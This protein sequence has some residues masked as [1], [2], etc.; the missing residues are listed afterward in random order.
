MLRSLIARLSAAALLVL[1]ATPAMAVEMLPDSTF[2]DAF[3]LANGLE[4][5][6]RH[7]PG[8]AAT[9]VTV[10]YRAGSAYEPAGREGLASLMAELQFTAPAGDTPERTR[11]DLGTLRPTGWGIHTNEH[12]V[13]LTEMVPN[14]KFPG[15]LREVGI[16]MRGVTVTDA[17][18]KVATANVR[19]DL[20]EL[21]FTRTDAALFS[22]V[23][24]LALGLSDEQIVRRA[25]AAGL[26]GL[27]AKDVTAELHKR[28]VP[29]NACI[30]LAGDF[31]AYNMKKLLESELGAIPAGAVQPEAPAPV[32]TPGTRTT[33][34]D[35]V[36]TP[37]GVVGAFAPAI[38]DT[39]H[40]TFYLAVLVMGPWLT[41]ELGRPA[42]PLRSRFQYSLFDEPDLVRFYPEV[43][44]GDHTP[45][46]IAHNLEVRLDQVA[47]MKVDA[48]GIEMLR[49]SVDWL[50]GGLFSPAALE[51]MHTQP[52]AL[53]TLSGNM[54]TRALWKGD[55]FWDV[56]RYRFENTVRSH[57]TFWKWLVA[58]EHQATLLFTPK[59]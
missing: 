13:T 31:S 25:S 30:A 15:L 53:A 56:Y 38:D 3:R 26:T 41:Q 48:P 34:W 12:L 23:R 43:Q 7:I 59:H 44:A 47:E 51:Q 17:I 52:G 19:R 55:A 46:A 29:A 57:N 6:V 10:G 27:K 21:T 20:A 37:L 5:R 42:P 49:F 50:L 11:E 24:S 40:P 32:L 1:L 8:A 39:L 35:G 14:D 28:Y 33:A 2:T 9:S 16:R 58:P 18:L 4:V 36:T 54:A 22:R 45:E